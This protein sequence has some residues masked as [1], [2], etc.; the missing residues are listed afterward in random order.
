LTNHERLGPEQRR[1]RDSA[2]FKHND[3]IAE[4]KQME[5][6]L[7]EAQ[8]MAAI[9]MAAAM[10]G[11]DLRNP[12]QTIVTSVSLWKRLWESIFPRLRSEEKQKIEGL[13][14]TIDEQVKYTDKIVSDLQD[15]AQPMKPDLVET[16]LRILFNSMIST[17]KIPKNVKV[18]IAIEKDFPKLMVDSILM[19]R[20]FAN[21]VT[22]A[23]QAMPKGGRL[24]IK[25][26]KKGKTAY[27][28]FQDTGV[29]IP[30]ENL[31]K[32]FIPLFTTK[33]KGQGFGLPVC[34]R[35]VEAHDGTITVKSKVGGGS[36]FT[37]EIPAG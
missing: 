29:G 16:N 8:W 31:D 14:E 7:H 5:E 1:E 27:I 10:V 33:A 20:A 2:H 24:A 26:S 34:K 17:M 13:V 18:S 28:S 4:R 22:N 6:K 23:L 12:M 9:G 32:L 15:Y 11:H 3:S 30:E 37:V 36:T 25:A 21:L 35:I 19:R